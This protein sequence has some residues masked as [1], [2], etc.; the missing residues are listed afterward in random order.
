[1][2]ACTAQSLALVVQNLIRA[3]INQE[4]SSLM[5][6]LNDVRSILHIC[7]YVGLGYFLA[8]ADNILIL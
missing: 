1:M 8:C 2:C 5:E 7:M 4:W 3:P 6:R